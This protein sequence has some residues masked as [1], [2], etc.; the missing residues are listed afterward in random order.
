LVLVLYPKNSECFQS[1]RAEKKVKAC[2]PRKTSI[3]ANTGIPSGSVRFRDGLERN[4]LVEP[5]DR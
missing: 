3:M 5:S 1:C 4:E 2:E